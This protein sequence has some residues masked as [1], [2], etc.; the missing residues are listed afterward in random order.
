MDTQEE[1]KQGEEE[2]EAQESKSGR[3]ESNDD[4]DSDKATLTPA[5][6]AD[7]DEMQAVLNGKHWSWSLNSRAI[8]VVDPEIT[9]GSDRK[10]A[11]MHWLLRFLHALVTCQLALARFSKRLQQ[12]NTK[13]PPPG[14]PGGHVGK[15]LEQRWAALHVLKLVRQLQGMQGV[16]VLSAWNESVRPWLKVVRS[17]QV[18]SSDELPDVFGWFTNKGR[19]R[20]MNV[21]LHLAITTGD[22]SELKLQCTSSSY[23]QHDTA[24]T[25][26]CLVGAFYSQLYVPELYRALHLLKRK[27][28]RVGE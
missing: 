15:L 6:A 14:P 20:L 18:V 19:Q 4:D 24:L 27:G 26:D 25:A 28:D 17:V 1:D 11:D 16:A 7:G 2:L 12:Y 3:Q 8:K 13:H 22:L 5:A 10:G 9:A 21:A 23:R